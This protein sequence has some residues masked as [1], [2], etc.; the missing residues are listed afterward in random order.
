MSFLYFARDMGHAPPFMH[1]GSGSG[2]PSQQVWFGPQ[3]F[4]PH[5]LPLNDVSHAFCALQKTVF[6]AP[7]ASVDLSSASVGRWRQSHCG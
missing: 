7:G 3:T 4:F 6:S 5:S 2:T 1:V